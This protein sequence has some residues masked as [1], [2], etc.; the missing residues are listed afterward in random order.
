M[1]SLPSTDQHNTFQSLCKLQRRYPRQPVL[2]MTA[3]NSY[4]SSLEH[5]IDHVV[6]WQP[7]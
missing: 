7:I 2:Q 3:D 1:T 6:S 5:G 4:T